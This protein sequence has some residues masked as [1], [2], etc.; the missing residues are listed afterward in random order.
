[1]RL[2]GCLAL[3]ACLSC[4]PE[5]RGPLAGVSDSWKNAPPPS[6]TSTAARP[7]LWALYTEAQHWP[8]A[9]L[10]PFRSR[11]HQ[12]EQLVD[13]RPNEIARASYTGLVADTVF[14]N[15][16]VLLQ[17][18]HPG[19]NEGFGYAMLK[20]GGHW[21]FV[22]LDAK[23]AVLESGALALCAGCHAQA[24]ADDVFGLPHSP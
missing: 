3:G 2:G 5:E 18:P 6:A 10:E 16:S 14:P 7:A 23:G 8:A 4:T 24:P 11:G 15:G 13:V 20:D 21:S 9:N 22:Q 12:P 17:Q 1:V 19:R